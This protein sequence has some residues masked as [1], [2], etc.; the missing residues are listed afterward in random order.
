VFSPPRPHFAASSAPGRNP[1]IP[2]AVLVFALLLLAALATPGCRLS[3]PPEFRLNLEGRDP[4]SVSL[5][6]DE[7]IRETLAEL[8][9]TPDEPRVP[10]GSGLDL[11]LLQAAAGPVASDAEG[12]QRGLYRQ[13]CA[14]CHG[15]SGDGAG[16]SAALLNPYPR[17]YRRGI[18]KFTSTL[19][20]IKPT[21]DDLRMTL[22]RGIPGTA[23]PSFAR[24]PEEELDALV[25]YVKYLSIRGETEQYLLQLVLDEDEYLPLD[26]EL[27]RDE[28]LLPAVEAWQ[29]PEK[30]PALVVV[31]PPRPPMD[32]PQDRQASIAR[33]KELYAK[34]DSQCVKCHGTAGKG[35]GEQTD[36]Y[37]DWNKPKQGVTAAETA[38]LAR[39]FTLPAQQIRPRDFTK[40]IFRGGS[41]PEDLYLRI[42]IGVKGTPM[43]GV[44][45]APGV[46]AVLTPEEIWDV[47]NYVR[48]LRQ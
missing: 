25:E 38:D 19:P 14:G 32:T 40:G 28:G 42:D 27:V 22:L 15:I 29:S 39:R 24:L 11:A 4:K 35:D 20:G 5:T 48:S 44:G 26:K 17:D 33:G 36:L 46:K 41:R 1:P 23:M 31:P 8:F 10:E 47:V 2:R 13:H 30:D 9:G 34:K 21:K 16:P 37:D 12:T 45:A 6:Q 43:P 18:F 3:E 7:A